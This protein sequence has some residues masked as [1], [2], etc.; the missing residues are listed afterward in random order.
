MANDK[1]P[2]PTD[3][4]SPTPT[5]A[6]AVSAAAA[7]AAKGGRSP[8]FPSITYSEAEER[9][10]RLWTKDKQFPMTKDVASQH[11]GFS[12]S[13]GAT[14]PLFA[15]MKRYGLLESVGPDLRVTN[16]AHFMFL[17]PFDSQD[18]IEMRKNLAMKPELFGEVM[19]KYA[20]ID[21]TLPSDGTLKARLQYD[22]KFASEEAAET[23]IKALRESL[24]IVNGSPVVA[25][26]PSV[27]NNGHPITEPQMPTPLEVALR[28]ALSP[29]AASFPVVHPMST[30]ASDH[31]RRWDLGGGTVMTV[32]MPNPSELR[33]HHIDRLKRYVT[34]LEMEASIAWDD[35]DVTT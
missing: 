10:F 11:L 21:G 29:A 23:F 1:A 20:G 9:A 5:F 12:K 8:N 22:L 33:K 26:G 19:Q 15:A 30:G 14:L 2:Q 17:H 18:R 24:A 3:S 31:H 7:A 27:D 28:T 35:D 4:S 13:S 25:R 32:V 16:D 6:A 34:A